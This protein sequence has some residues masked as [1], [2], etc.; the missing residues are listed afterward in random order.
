MILTGA[1]IAQAVASGLISIS[2]F[3]PDQVNPNSYN[4]RLCERL[5]IYDTPI[6]DALADQS[7]SEIHICQEGYL[8]VPGQVYL[9]TTVEEIG[10]HHF[11]PSL[12]GRSSLG[13]LGMF[14]QVSADLGNLGAIHQWTLEIVVVQP[15]RVYAN[16]IVGQV[17]FWSTN[18]ARLEYDGYFGKHNT[19]ELP[20]AQSLQ[21]GRLQ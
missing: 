4:Y 5:R 6:V 8:L 19:P 18:G 14:L 16:M 15:L 2:P 10:S 11:V 20:V 13:R 1:E 17:S 9:G 3:H 21:N 7:Y 12:I